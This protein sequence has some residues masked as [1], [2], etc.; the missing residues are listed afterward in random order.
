M[1]NY[2]LTKQALKQL[3]LLAK[4]EIKTAKKIKA[5]I[6][7]LREDLISGESLQGYTQFKK[8]ALGNS[9]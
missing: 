5:V 3:T 6:M 1:R 7:K 8:Y 4:N 2:K 9:G